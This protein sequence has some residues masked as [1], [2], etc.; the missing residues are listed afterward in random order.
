MLIQICCPQCETLFGDQI[1]YGKRAI[2]WPSVVSCVSC[3]SEIVVQE[4]HIR[5][6]YRGLPSVTLEEHTRRQDTK[7]VAFKPKSD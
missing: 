7:V 2:K 4:E 1:V 5:V 6:S 3:K